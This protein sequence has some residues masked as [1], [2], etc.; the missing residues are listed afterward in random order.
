MTDVAEL[1]QVLQSVT[2][3]LLRVGIDYHVTGGLASSYYGE[4]RFTQDIDLV[5]PAETIASVSLG[6]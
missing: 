4:P 6:R 3:L 1:E 2:S 5:I